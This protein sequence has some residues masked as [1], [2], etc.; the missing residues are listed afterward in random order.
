MAIRID[1]ELTAAELRAALYAGELVVLTRI[2]AV[3]ELAAYTAAELERLFA[4]HPPERAHEHLSPEAM[5]ALLG[6]WKP[7]F[8]RDPRVNE[9]VKAII[10]GAGLDPAGTLYD[11]PK[12]RTSFP[13]DHLT[14]GVAFAF[15]WHR[16][17]WYAAPAA[18]IN[19]WLP[20]SRLSERNA[21]GFDLAHFDRAVRNDSAGFDYYALNANR[22][23]IAKQVGRE[24]Q[25]RPGATDHQVADEVVLLPEPGAIVLFSGAQ[26]H[27]SISNTSGLARYSVDFRT[28]DALD[29]AE[30]RGAPLVDVECTGTSIRDFHGV[31]DGEQLPEEL[32][33]AVYGD[34]PADAVLVY[35]PPPADAPV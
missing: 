17:T 31:I 13:S 29:V 1:P 25:A 7:A 23:N 30:G 4:P 16:D 22:S 8:M 35:E 5:A 3:G 21:M 34:P 15:P 10:A 9:L 6:R 12:F 24:L 27:R 2:A 20:V 11:L 18:Q 28:V 19:W 26:L 33:R 14:T 32:I